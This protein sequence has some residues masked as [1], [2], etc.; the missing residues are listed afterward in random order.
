MALSTDQSDLQEFIA[1][2]AT[3]YDPA[4]DTYRRPPFAQP[5]KAG[6]NSPIYNAHSYH[7]KVPPKGIVPYI[8]HYTDYTVPAAHVLFTQVRPFR[9][10]VLFYEEAEAVAPDELRRAQ[11]ELKVIF[12]APRREETAN[13]LAEQV[14]EEMKRWNERAERVVLQLRP[15]GY[16]IPE[17]L[18]RSRELANLVTRFSNPGKVVKAFLE[19]LEA[20]RTWHAEVQALY[21]F[22]RDKRLPIFQRARGL[23]EEIKR[24]EGVPGTELLAEEEPQ[25]RRERLAELV[26]SGRA[27]YEW[28]DLT[29]A[30]TPLQERFRQVYAAL[31]RQ[32]DE[33]VAQAKER[34][35]AAGVPVRNSLL[36]YECRGLEWSEDGLH[37]AY[38]HASLKELPLQAAALP[39]L[40]RELRERHETDVQYGEERR[41]VRHLRVAEVVP[42]RRIKNEAEL[43]EVLDAL[44]GA[45]TA[46]LDKVEVVELE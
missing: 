11:D 36:P 24:A 34:L 18:Q 19:N 14:R 12:D 15:A 27:A 40:V 3:P 41:K 42:K 37:C 20:V 30:L 1:Q 43:E 35:E 38:C 10:A 8:E 33:A 32:R 39:N 4:T 22:I 7:T 13:A 31:H 23:L 5:V 2:H 28:E 16:S 25:R 21:G 45:V 6:K 26:A 17:P 44:R 46:A 29:A 9:R